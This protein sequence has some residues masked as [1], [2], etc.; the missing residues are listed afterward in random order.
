MNKLIKLLNELDINFKLLSECEEV[1]FNRLCAFDDHGDNL[2]YFYNKPDPVFF[3]KLAGFK[4]S[5]VLLPEAWLY[6]EQINAVN[7]QGINAVFVSK[8]RG[9]AAQI[10]GSL[11]CN[12]DEWFDGIHPTA[13]IAEGARIAPDVCIGPFSIIGQCTIGRGSKI[14]ANCRIYNDVNIGMNASIRD[15]CSIGGV[16]FGVERLQDDSL[17]RFPHVGTVIIGDDVSLYPYVNIDRGTFGATT[18]GRGTFID[19]FCHIGHNSTVG[20]N[21]IITAKTV[22]CGKA[23]VEDCVWVGVGSV[24]REGRTVEKNSTVGIG[25]IVVQ[26]VLAGSTVAGNPAKVLTK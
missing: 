20:Q 22:L 9:V 5:S 23:V 7:L 6:N 15:Y 4:N 17:V 16:G 21:C 25:S 8:P 14:G 3:E 18:V 11:S 19:H 10:Q 26:N 12:D 13:I 2:L 1:H 24:I